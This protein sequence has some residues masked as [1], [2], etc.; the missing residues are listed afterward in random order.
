[1]ALLSSSMSMPT[2]GVVE[3]SCIREHPSPSGSGSPDD[4]VSANLLANAQQQ[5]QQ[6]Q[7][8]VNK[9]R[10]VAADTAAQRRR[11]RQQRTAQH[12]LTTGRRPSRTN[13]RDN[14]EDEDD[15]DEENDEDDEEEDDDDERDMDADV[16][17]DAIIDSRREP[18]QQQQQ[19]IPKLQPIHS[20]HHKLQQQQQQQQL[21]SL[22]WHDF[23]SSILS[24]F[25]HLRDVEDFV[26]VTL[27][28]DGKSFTAHKMVLSAC[29]PY[30]RHLLKVMIIILMM[31]RFLSV[32]ST[33]KKGTRSIIRR[34]TTFHLVV[35][36]HRWNCMAVVGGSVSVSPFTSILDV[37]HT[38]ERKEN[39]KRGKKGHKWDLRRSLVGVVLFWEGRLPPFR[40]V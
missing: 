9:R 28:C 38:H 2:A 37:R 10:R 21:Y 5:Q 14:S 25:R 33:K 15:G 11:H 6:Q 4:N 17:E 18:Q 3:E 35:W 16:E 13:R 32:R 8:S 22:R 26:D 29:S 24:S 7:H 31:I 34:V 40:A 12:R 19:Q 36:C 1:M 23:Q 30:F 20:Q 27:A 39:D